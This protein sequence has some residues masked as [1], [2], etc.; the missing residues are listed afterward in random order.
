MY[1]RVL[2]GKHWACL[3]HTKLN[4]S[5]ST[6]A[7]HQ[8][9]HIHTDHSETYLNQ[10]MTNTY[11]A[12]VF[13]CMCSSLSW[14]VYITS[15]CLIKAC[16][17][18]GTVYEEFNALP[19]YTQGLSLR[20]ASPLAQ[21]QFHTI[22]KAKQ[23]P[24]S[25]NVYKKY[26]KIILYKEKWKTPASTGPTK[27]STEGKIKGISSSGNSMTCKYVHVCTHSRQDTPALV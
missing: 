12:L 26:H 1:N 9:M 24:Q 5:I 18:V 23:N 11:K 10:S 17:D 16:S 4:T 15:S 3:L 6:T 22:V 7:H 13:I 8:D 2:E 20:M 25:I 27:S 21:N 14:S 19:S